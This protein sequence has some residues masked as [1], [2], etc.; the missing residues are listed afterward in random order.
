LSS[1]GF[2]KSYFKG[3]KPWDYDIFINEAIFIE[4]MKRKRLQLIFYGVS[5]VMTGKKFI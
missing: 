1:S 3:K 5:E 2:S 4:I